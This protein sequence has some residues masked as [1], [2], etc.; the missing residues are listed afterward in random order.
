MPF[1]G[2]GVHGVAEGPGRRTT[3][4]SSPRCLLS[5]LLQL[6]FANLATRQRRQGS[7]EDDFARALV[8][9]KAVFQPVLQIGRR[10][11]VSRTQL[12]ESNDFL[13]ESHVPSDHRRPLY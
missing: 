6:V 4:V 1:A 3:I 12:D 10:R 2:P 8:G 7:K 9:R 11:V 13:V 5:E